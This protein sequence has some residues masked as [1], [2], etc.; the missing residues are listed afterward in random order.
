M[1]NIFLLSKAKVVNLR[2]FSSVLPFPKFLK[3]NLMYFGH[4]HVETEPNCSH[5]F[6][7]FLKYHTALIPLSRHSKHFFRVYFLKILCVLCNSVIWGPDRCIQSLPKNACCI[8]NVSQFQLVR[9]PI[10]LLSE[11][12]PR[13]WGVPKCLVELFSMILPILL[14]FGTNLQQVMPPIRNLRTFSFF[15]HHAGSRHQNHRSWGVGT[16]PDTFFR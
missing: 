1:K 6:S 14:L 11:S 9:N 3:E 5:K 7:T 10:S 13:I 12:S 15:H 2:P 16:S 8:L 4:K